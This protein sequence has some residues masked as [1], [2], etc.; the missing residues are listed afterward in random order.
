MIISLH[1]CV[2]EVNYKNMKET[3][4]S[5]WNFMRWLRLIMGIYI[6]ITSITGKNYVFAMIGGFFVFQAITNSGCAA[7]AAVP[8]SKVDQKDTESIEFE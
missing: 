4:L 1:H 7:C 3:I 6:I 2:L 5:G 8:V